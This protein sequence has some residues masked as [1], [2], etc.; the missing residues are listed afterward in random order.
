MTAQLREMLEERLC[1]IREECGYG[2]E[3]IMENLCASDATSARG[4]AEIAKKYRVLFI[5]EA[6]ANFNPELY[7]VSAQ[8]TLFPSPPASGSIQDGNFTSSCG[9]TLCP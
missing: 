9:T 1:A 6:T 4:I 5:E 2:L 8:S 7:G 3:I